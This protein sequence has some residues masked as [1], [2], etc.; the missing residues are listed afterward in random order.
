MNRAEWGWGSG[1][2]IPSRSWMGFRIPYTL[3]KQDRFQKFPK[4]HVRLKICPLNHISFIFTTNT[5]YLNIDKVSE[6]TQ[7]LSC[8]LCRAIRRYFPGLEAQKNFFHKIHNYDFNSTKSWWNDLESLALG[9]V[10]P[11]FLVQNW[12]IFFLQEIN[13][14]PIWMPN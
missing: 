13:I 8:A 7:Y 14:W 12:K 3:T 1:I 6:L 11:K 4:I 9:S 5:W 2:H 10:G